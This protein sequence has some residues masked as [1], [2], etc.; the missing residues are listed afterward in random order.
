MHRKNSPAPRVS[1]A[2]AEKA[3]GT[4][5]YGTS[6]SHDKEQTTD[7]HKGRDG[8]HRPN[9]GEQKLGKDKERVENQAKQTGQ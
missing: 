1:N 7:R 3:S 4:A 8:A 9:A 6:P 2:E 5:I